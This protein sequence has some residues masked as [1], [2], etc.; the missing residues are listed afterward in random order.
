MAATTNT[1][2]LAS[3]FQPILDEIYKEASKSAG[4]DAKTKPVS[5]AGA[6]VVSVYQNTLYGLGTYS[7]NDGYPDGDV[8]GEWVTLTLATERG[9]KMF[10]DRLDNEETLGEAMGSTVGEFM[11]LF[12][13]PELDAYRFAKY[14]TG[15]GNTVGA[16]CTLSAATIL[17]A[18]D[19]A[20]GQMDDDEVPE[21]GRKLYLSSTC[22]RFLQAAITRMLGNESSADRR[23][24]FLDGVEL[25]KVPKTR[26]Y[27]I[28]TLNAGATAQVGGY[29]NAGVEVN[30]LMI[31]PTAIMQVKKHAKLKLFNPDENQSKDGWSVQYRIYHDAFVYDNKTDGIYAHTKAA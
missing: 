25:I 21:E 20:A 14:A 23:L 11:R 27:T 31:H 7:R 17:A 1:I 4:M 29:T 28:C 22:M 12:V 5:F 10:I 8:M 26:F 24:A 9:R 18:I 15:A 6:N 2:V 19:V 13:V 3:K 16:P 30:F